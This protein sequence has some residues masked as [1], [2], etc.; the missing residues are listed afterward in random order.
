M[1]FSGSSIWSSRYL[2][3]LDSKYL[4]QFLVVFAEQLSIP[5]ARTL[6]PS[7]VSVLHKFDILCPLALHYFI[8]SCFFIIRGGKSSTFLEG[9]LFFLLLN[10]VCYWDIIERF[11]FTVI[12]IYKISIWLFLEFLLANHS[13]RSHIIFLSSFCYWFMNSLTIFNFTSL[14][15]HTTTLISQDIIVERNIGIASEK[16]SP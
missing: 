10:M 1:F 11:W 8:N 4:R 7:C 16:F 2:L 6:E 14:N 13:F 12:S 15:N 5:L 9:L 3:Y